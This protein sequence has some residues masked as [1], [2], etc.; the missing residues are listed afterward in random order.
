MHGQKTLI[1]LGTLTETDTYTDYFNA[2]VHAYHSITY[3]KI[4]NYHPGKGRYVIEWVEPS[5]WD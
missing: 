5:H 2:T 3:Y 4:V 1:S